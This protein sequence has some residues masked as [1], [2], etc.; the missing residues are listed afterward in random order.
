MTIDTQVVAIR[1][2]FLKNKPWYCEYITR[3]DSLGIVHKFI[4]LK[5]QMPHFARFCGVK[6]LHRFRWNEAKVHIVDG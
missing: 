5:C 2:G 6:K 3:E 1:G 4:Q